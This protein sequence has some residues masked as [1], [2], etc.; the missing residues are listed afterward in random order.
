MAI[1][2]MS[3]NT[4]DGTWSEGWHQLT[5][6]KAEYGDWNDKNF[7]DVWF[8]GYPDNFNLRIYEAINKETHEEFALA[9]FFKLAN[10]GILDKV[11]SPS[12]K[13][14]IQYDDD[15]A[16]LVG[17]EINGYFYKKG[18]YVE[19]SDRIA[20]VAQEGKVI[21]YN[22]DDVD[23]WKGVAEKHVKEYVKKSTPAVSS[24]TTTDITS[25]D[26]PF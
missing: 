17:K 18:K 21:S 25:D 3:Y 23:F 2:T 16:G 24:T 9:K 10:A 4:G 8:K 14:A 22:E 1:K 15:E 7:L 19:I 26:I 6:E 20:P 12:G 13:E 5:I 11:K